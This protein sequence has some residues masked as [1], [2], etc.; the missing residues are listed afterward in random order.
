MQVTNSATIV[1]YF[2]EAFIAEADDIK[3]MKVLN[4]PPQGT[5]ART[6]S[7]LERLWWS[8]R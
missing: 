7:L 1:D 2:P 8:R 5:A 6:R 4:G 3:G